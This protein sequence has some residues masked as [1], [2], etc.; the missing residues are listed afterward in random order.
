M[1]EYIF[2]ACL[3]LAAYAYFGYPLLLWA[4]ASLRRA[5]PTPQGLNGW[6]SVS[7]IIAA[8]NEE[9]SIGAKLENSLALDY[10]KDRLEI[11][12][13]ANGCTD[14]TEEIVRRF[15]DRGVK[16]VSLSSPGKTAAQNAAAAMALGEVVIFSDAHCSYEPHAL[17]HLAAHF[18]NPRV[19]VVMGRVVWGDTG[20]PPAARGEGLYWRYE[21]FLKTQESRLGRCLV[22]SGA[23]MAM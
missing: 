15:A 21:D 19:G 8:Y 6:P 3:G 12:V 11:I 1:V 17:T 7:L 2:W 16:L 18:S 9:K 4:L 20:A 10:P 13:A 5:P 14:G 23:I 22:G